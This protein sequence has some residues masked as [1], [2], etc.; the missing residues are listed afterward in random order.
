MNKKIELLREQLLKIDSLK[1]SPAY[2]PEF[3]IWNNTTTKLIGELFDDTY[4]GM[5]RSCEVNIMASSKE[6]HYN[7]FL[8]SLANKKSFIINAIQEYERLNNKKVIDI[9]KGTDISNYDFHTMVKEVSSKLFEN[10]H[11][12]QAVEEAFKK[13]IKEIK[14]YYHYKTGVLLDG[15]NLMNKVFGCENQVPIIK[16]NNLS[17]LE[18]KDEQ[19]GIMYLYKGIVGI[20]NRKT[21]DN[22][23]LEDSNRAIEYLTLASLLINLFEE[24]KN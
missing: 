1:H 17:N 11:Y 16:F 24:Y 2:H 14:E 20:R 4:L 13:V 9:S 10:K 8:R 21:H 15:D 23:T 7:H 12:A 18:E 22:V 6:D 19:K 3:A 5:Y